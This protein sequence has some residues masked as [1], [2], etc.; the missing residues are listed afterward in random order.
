MVP[1]N[2]QIGHPDTQAPRPTAGVTQTLDYAVGVNPATTTQTHPAV[3]I[4][5]LLLSGLAQLYLWSVFFGSTPGSGPA[6]AA[7][8]GL[9][10]VYLTVVTSVLRWQRATTHT[11][12]LLTV[13]VLL[14]AIGMRW[15]M[16]TEA[17]L[18]EDDFKR[19]LLDGTILRSGL[20]PYALT[21][22]DVPELGGLAVP[23]PGIGTIYPPLAELLFAGLGRSLDSWRLGALGADL[24]LALTLTLWFGRG[25]MLVPVL[26]YLWNPLVLKDLVNAAHVDVWAVLCIALFLTAWNSRRHAL[27]G[28][29]IA[30][31][32]LIK[33]WP[34]ML[35]VVWLRSMTCRR[36]RLW[37]A[38]LLAV[39]VGVAFVPFLPATP[40]ANLIAF[41]ANIEG[42]GG[43]F[44]L[45]QSVLAPPQARIVLSGLG[46]AVLLHVLLASPACRFTRWPDSR[47]LSP[48]TLDERVPTCVQSLQLVIL[49]F[50]FLTTGFPWYLGSVVILLAVRWSPAIAGFVALT[51]LAYFAPPAL[52]SGIA[53]AAL[54]TLLL[55]W[56]LHE[57][58]WDSMRISTA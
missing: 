15:I 46:A 27:A 9:W 4:A 48:P 3:P 33:L 38:G 18:G 57:W 35:A 20:N 29:C 34:A 53:V 52:A 42:K 16:L 1:D 37:Y 50:C 36:Q 25:R 7:L 49:L 41:F 56:R 22:A 6:V 28:V 39:L 14:M 2:P 45:L 26:V 19:Y 31:A 24:A 8:S 55:S 11:P 12:V 10:V 5:A 58:R 40:L 17:P 51:H 23:L 54:A 32:T 21:P 30:A 44:V 47:A 43:L 13:I